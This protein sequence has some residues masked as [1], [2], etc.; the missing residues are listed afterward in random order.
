M[1]GGMR[2]RGG[3][4]RRGEERRGSL[5]H[6]L[7][8]L[9]LQSIRQSE[10]CA[11]WTESAVKTDTYGNTNSAHVRAHMHTSIELQVHADAHMPTVYQVEHRKEGR[12]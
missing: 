6:L 1:R 2:R 12:T 9:L 11:I 5:V 7:L 3:E 4:E 10:H 8:L